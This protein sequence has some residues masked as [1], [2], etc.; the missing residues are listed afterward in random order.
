MKSLPSLVI[1]LSLLLTPAFVRARQ[2]EEPVSQQ[3]AERQSTVSPA[4]VKPG[5]PV[6]TEKDLYE[7]SGFFHPFLRMPMYVLRDQK[8][9]WS[10]PA[11]TTK[12]DVKWWAIL[13]GATAALIAT[14][15][16]TVK[17]LRNSDDQIAEGTWGSRVGSAYS[18]IPISSVFYFAGTA[19]H[20]KRLR[21]TG[22][23]GFETLID[24]A[25]VGEAVKIVT[26]RARPLEAGGKG[27]FED[28]PN[29]RWNSGFPSGHALSSWAMASLIAHQYPHPRIVP[30]LAYGLASV[31]VISRVGARQHFPGDVV[32]GS[33]I[34][35][36]IGDFVYGKRHDRDL[37]QKPAIARRILSR[38]R[39]GAAID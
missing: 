18:L 26:D 22:L 8:A 33:A 15:R 7:G 17:A 36:F 4:E 20:E 29:A 1:V 2:S 5:P 30:I 19:T 38:I 21:E 32:A 14:D 39:I 10:S 35:W 34:G 16:W 28:S 3:T 24:T 13:G 25:L 9:I 37:E 23:L 31:V 27:R 11:H 12:S 6:N